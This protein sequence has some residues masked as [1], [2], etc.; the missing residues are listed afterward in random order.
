MLLTVGVSAQGIHEFSSSDEIHFV[1]RVG[2][3]ADQESALSLQRSLESMGYQPI[4][5][6]QEEGTCQV[7]FGTFERFLDANLYLEDLQAA[8]LADDAEILPCSALGRQWDAEARGPLGTFFH[9]DVS[10]VSEMDLMTLSGNTLYES[11][12]RIDANEGDTAFREALLRQRPEHGISDPIRGY[13]DTNLGILEIIDGNWEA[14]FEL[15]RPVADG[16]VASAA[17]HRVMAMI[18]VAWLTHNHGSR[19]ARENRLAAYRAYREI[20]RFTGS[21]VVRARCAVECV[22][23]MMELAETEVAGE[24]RGS[25]RTMGTHEEVRREAHAAFESIQPTSRIMIRHRST[26]ELM[27]L[28]TFARQPDPDFA[29]AARLGEDFVERHQSLGEDAPQREVAAALHQTGMYHLRLGNL[30]RAQALFE[31]VIDEVPEDVDHFAG[32]N[33]RAQA[34]M[35]MAHIARGVGDHREARQ[36]MRDVIDLYPEDVGSAQ[37]RTRYPNLERNVE[38]SRR[39]SRAHGNTQTADSATGEVSISELPEHIEQTGASHGTE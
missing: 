7:L 35:G 36:L 19:S 16:E 6:R 39:W 14:A 10:H 11:L 32:I 22:G 4:E 13:I 29:T 12:E 24:P 31:R 25:R 9:L 27:F 18:R 1:I 37:I 28:E 23:I 15:C 8:G 5:I 3:F 21:D 33:P 34:L 30:E 17:A 20:G 26:L 2:T 38:P